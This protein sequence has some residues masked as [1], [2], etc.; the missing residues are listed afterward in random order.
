MHKLCFYNFS[1][2]IMKDLE[3]VLD[4]IEFGN[5]NLFNPIGYKF[6][7]YLFENTYKKEEEE[8]DTYS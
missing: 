5:E 7:L 1:A 2:I 8:S 4:W 6:T 3:S